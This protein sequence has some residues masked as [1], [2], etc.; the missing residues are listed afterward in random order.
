MYVKKEKYWECPYCG[1]IYER[2]LRFNKVQIDGLAGIND[3]VRSTLSKLLSLD[4][5]GADRDLS[6]CEKID[7]ASVGTMIA[8]ISVSLFKSFYTKDR[9]NEI[10]KVNALLPKFNRDFPEMDDAE[11]ILYDFIDSSDIYALLLVVYSMTGQSARK[12]IIY[13]LL[14]CDE[15]FNPNISRHLLNILLKDQK[16]EDADTI[17]N[18]IVAANCKYGIMS[19]LSSYPDTEQKAIHIN[20]MLDK[21]NAETDLS[22]LFDDYFES[23]N[24]SGAAVVDIF[25]SAVAHKVNFNTTRVI[26]AV[27]QNCTTVEIAE[28]TF[29]AMSKSRFDEATATAIL[30]WASLKSPNTDVS[31]I[32]F[33]SLFKGN[34]VFELTDD[35]LIAVMTSE[36]SEDIKQVKVTQMLETFKVSGKNLDRTL[37]FHMIENMGSPEY[38]KQVFDILAS[39]VTSIPLSVIEEY[40]LKTDYDK[41]FKA[42]FL[43]ASLDKLRMASIAS[44]VFSQYIKTPVDSPEVREKVMLVFLN[45][46]LNP[47]S[48]AAGYY[49]S[50]TAERPSDAVL[51]ILDQRSCKVAANTIDRYIANVADSKSFNPKIAN[52]AMKGSFMISP[53]C[54]RKYLL[55]ITEPENKKIA[56]ISK[57]L[58]V[59]AGDIRNMELTFRTAD[60]DLVGNIAQA[61]FFLSRDDIYVVQEVVGLLQREKIKLDAPMEQTGDRKKVKIKKFIE[62]NSSKMS[63][64]VETLAKELKL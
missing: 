48:D 41:E 62:A 56:R 17:L 46:Q 5:S 61:Y 64:T 63:K 2:E 16:I 42:D 25:L 1:K 26:D 12:E 18:N 28:K 14:D 10:S 57:M 22:K 34:S 19:V 59:C 52:L 27:L 45:H 55:T 54:F 38:R 4:F 37:A 53:V 51:N 29:S 3:L 23:N 49:L 31:K 60:T 33:E 30:R 40:L 47:D 50:N 21:V 39:R 36:Q 9:Q 11:E 8:K 15:V 32:A 20:N 7:H 6:E 44:G 24:D 43:S 58:G 13:G 35:E